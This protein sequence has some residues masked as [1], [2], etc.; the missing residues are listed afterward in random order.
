MTS[1]LERRIAKVEAETR[2]PVQAEWQR[3]ILHEED[4]TPERRAEIMA[5]G[6]N[7]IFRIILSDAK[8]GGYADCN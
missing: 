8:G 5:N 2:P 3:V 4:D 6:K 1:A 7:T